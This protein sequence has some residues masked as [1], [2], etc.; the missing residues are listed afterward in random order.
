MSIATETV[1][2][3]RTD[4]TRTRCGLD[5]SAAPSPRTGQDVTCG[6]CKRL[7]YIPLAHD[8]APRCDRC[9]YVLTKCDCLDRQRWALMAGMSA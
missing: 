6:N 7:T 8:C 2:A 9:R 4:G 5:T 3:L 1:H